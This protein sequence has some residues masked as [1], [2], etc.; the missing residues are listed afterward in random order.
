MENDCYIVT[1][2]FYKKLKI[3][4]FGISEKTSIFLIIR[5]NF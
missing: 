5:A 3:K 4:K 2:K 1:N